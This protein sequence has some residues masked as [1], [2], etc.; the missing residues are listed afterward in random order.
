[1]RYEK[2]IVL[3]LNAQARPVAGQGPLGCYT[4]TSPG[5]TGYCVDGG[6]PAS[7]PEGVCT[8]GG[9]PSTGFCFSGT[10]GGITDTCTSGPVPT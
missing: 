3:D 6:D 5:G 9:D 1:M 8:G 2:P 10:G 7:I 4:G